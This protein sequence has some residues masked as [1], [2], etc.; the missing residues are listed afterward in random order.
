M[1]EPAQFYAASCSATV[2]SQYMKHINVLKYNAYNDKYVRPCNTRT[3]M[4]TGSMH[5]TMSLVS[6]DNTAPQDRQTHG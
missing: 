4:Y 1:L 6:H 2:T 5:L 3:E